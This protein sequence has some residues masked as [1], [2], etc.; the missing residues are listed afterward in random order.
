MTFLEEAQDNSDLSDFEFLSFTV[1]DS[2][3]V[4]IESRL[5]V[6]KYQYLHDK[7]HF[8]E[9]MKSQPYSPSSWFSNNS[10]IS[11]IS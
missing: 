7:K 8:Y 2:M 11:G 5:Y 3:L 4:K 1:N 10:V 9:V 6:E